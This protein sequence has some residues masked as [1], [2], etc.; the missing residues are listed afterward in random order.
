[1]GAII[2][3]SLQAEAELHAECRLAGNQSG[4]GKRVIQLPGASFPRGLHLPRSLAPTAGGGFGSGAVKAG[5]R[6]EFIPP[7]IDTFFL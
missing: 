6:L 7:R 5:I 2:S 4:G 3:F 1:M